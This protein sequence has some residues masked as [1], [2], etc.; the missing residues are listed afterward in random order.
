MAHG[1]R[2]GGRKP[3]VPN[4]RTV[5]LAERLDALGLDPVLGLAKIAEDPTASLELRAKVLADLMSYMYPRRKALD[6]SAAAQRPVSI[7]LNI[8]AKATN[9]A[10][11]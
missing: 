9:E 6:V 1:I 10:D 2:T 5:E 8:P 3:G 7:Q 11:V 4:K